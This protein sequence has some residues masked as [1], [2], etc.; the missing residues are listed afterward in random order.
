[1]AV[2]L[3]SPGGLLAGLGYEGQIATGV[4]ST[5]RSRVNSGSSAIPFGRAVAKGTT[6]GTCKLLAGNTDVIVGISVMRP[7]HPLLSG[8]VAFNQYDDVP[9]LNEGEIYAKASETVVDGDGVIALVAGGG[10]LGSARVGKADTSG[11]LTIPNAFWVGDVVSG[12]IGK[13]AINTGATI[14]S[15]T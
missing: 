2:D 9:L 15:A 11:R 13:I 4:H 3:S 5:I 6:T 10:T 12:Q 8:A 7:L 1:M 14:Y